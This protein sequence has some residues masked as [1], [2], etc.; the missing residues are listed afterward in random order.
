M[1]R[2]FLAVAVIA[3]G[4]PM[5]A[6]ADQA[7][8]AAALGKAKMG[9]L[10]SGT[11]LQ[12]AYF[13]IPQS[14]NDC[15]ADFRLAV[16]NPKSEIVKKVDLTEATVARL[17]LADPKTA[18]RRYDNESLVIG[19]RSGDVME[20][21]FSDL[22]ARLVVEKALHTQIARCWPLAATPHR[23][24]ADIASGWHPDFKRAMEQSRRTWP[25]TPTAAEISDKRLANFGI[26]RHFVGTT[27]GYRSEGAGVT[28]KGFLH[29]GWDPKS[30]VIN[31]QWEDQSG[32]RGTA[33]IARKGKQLVRI[34]DGKVTHAAAI[35]AAG[36]D[37][38]F[39]P[40]ASGPPSIR[41]SAKPLKTRVLADI[42]QERARTLKSSGAI[43]WFKIE[44]EEERVPYFYHPSNRLDAIGELELSAQRV[45]ESRKL[46]VEIA[47]A[48]A[49]R[50]RPL[51][52]M[53][54]MDGRWF[55]LRKRAPEQLGNT[56]DIWDHSV[57]FEIVGASASQY[58]SAT[59]YDGWGNKVAS[60]MY[61]IDQGVVTGHYW[62]NTRK[63][64]KWQLASNHGMVAY[65][66]DT[67]SARLA[68][69]TERVTVP[70]GPGRWITL[71]PT[72]EAKV[73]TARAQYWATAQRLIDQAQEKIRRERA[74][75][76]AAMRAKQRAEEERQEMAA[77]YA[78]Q[79]EQQRR[80]YE[81]IIFNSNLS[82]ANYEINYG[83]GNGG[84]SGS[85]YSGGGSVSGAGYGSGG[86]TASSRAGSSSR[87]NVASP[88]SADSA[89][90][91]SSASGASA[92]AAP[93]A[94]R[95]AGAV[96]G[97]GGSGSAGTASASGST[98][99]IVR[100]DEKE[101]TRLAAEKVERQRQHDASV[102][103]REAESARK[104][105]A[106]KRRAEEWKAKR[107]AE[108]EDFYRRFPHCRPTS[109][110]KVTCQ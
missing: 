32:A 9:L 40:V 23:Y 86:S 94:S 95:G 44:A 38:R 77:Y 24:G 71:Y 8:L 15:V 57:H 106:E 110:S 54:Q 65:K 13:H 2:S 90:A 87:G 29:H 88:H 49:R 28:Y 81:A 73:R 21:N 102:A 27:Y 31:L 20:M 42:V 97:G 10:R 36:S 99:L 5:A 70:S 52:G 100:T 79:Q 6:K 78:R 64:E 107:D 37:I 62:P 12:I 56:T 109:T 17:F 22:S 75:R 43:H 72:T 7:E 35:P 103:A 14:G 84:S 69:D 16:P 101:R 45:A 46:H 18:G 55:A 76:L 19:G 108:R 50:L 61:S 3:M 33:V 67:R 48:D 98:S 47:A 53:Q 60:W 66:G 25:S 83:S 59:E 85:S 26:L 96:A 11:R 82:R 51:N 1:G 93:S 68:E 58:L 63:D 104:A 105:A 39:N 89:V 74:E 41:Y 30:G 4:W 80:Q 91:R 34:T 92:D